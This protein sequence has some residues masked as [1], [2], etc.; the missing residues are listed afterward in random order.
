MAATRIVLPILKPTLFG[1][2]ALLFIIHLK[3]YV[4]AL[5]LFSPGSE[6]MGTMMLFLWGAGDTG[7]VAAFASI[8]IVTTIIF[9]TAA[10]RIFKVNIYG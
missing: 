2:F 3:T 7:L 4:T 8:Q 5:F 1:C 9:V 10:R 6:V